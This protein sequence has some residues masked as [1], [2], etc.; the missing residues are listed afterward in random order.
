MNR[1]FYDTEFTDL[2]LNARLISIGLIDEM[3]SKTFYAELAD[4]YSLAD[5]SPFVRQEV[6]PLLED[7]NSRMSLHELG[8]Q[9]QRWLA[10]FAGPVQLLSD[11]TWD[12]L[13]IWDIF[14]APDAW[15][16]NLL[17]PG[18]V[19]LT[20]AQ[21]QAYVRTIEAGYATGLRRHHALDDAIANRRGWLAAQSQIAVGD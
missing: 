5:C 7:G 6:L 1:I 2:N 11:S 19:Q 15:P 8:K 9:L 14:G 17:R 10:G 13:F 4:T 20:P 3:G 12:H 16:S 21:Q 18:L